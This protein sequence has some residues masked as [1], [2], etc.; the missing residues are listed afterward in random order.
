MNSQRALAAKPPGILIV[1]ARLK[2]YQMGLLLGFCRKVVKVDTI[3]GGFES[4]ECSYVHEVRD[5]AD[6][7]L[8]EDAPENVDED[9]SVDYLFIIPASNTDLD[10]AA[11]DLL[12]LTQKPLSSSHELTS[13]DYSTEPQMH[14]TLVN[15]A[16]AAV[17]SPQ[18]WVWEMQ[19]PSVLKVAF[20]CMA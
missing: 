12:H 20:K 8:R 17:G 3:A 2:Q 16:E 7:E 10:K 14:E 13:Q 1:G 6:D 5:A 11:R 4:T 19:R 15:W 18:E 9:G